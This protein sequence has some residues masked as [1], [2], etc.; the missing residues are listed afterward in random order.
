[1]HAIR[2]KENNENNNHHD[3][4]RECPMIDSKGG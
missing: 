4:E 2:G 3:D 1:M